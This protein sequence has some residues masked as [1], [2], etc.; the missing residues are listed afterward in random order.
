[1]V[2]VTR[3]AARRQDTPANGWSDDLRWYAAAIHR[4]KDLTPQLDDYRPMAL[5]ANDLIAKRDRTPAETQELIGLIDTMAPIIEQ[6][7]DP[8][9]LGYQAQVH[10]TWMLRPDDWPSHQGQQVLWTEC[11]HGNWFF[12]PWHRAYLLEYEAVVR[13]HIEAL[14]GPH[15][16]WGLPYW[17]S[18]DYLADP[19]A[20]LLPGPLADPFVPDDVDVPGLVA[21]PGEPRGN[22]L[23][24]PSRAGPEPLVGPPSAVDWP[25]ASAALTRRHYANADGANFVSFGGGYLEDLTQF[26]GSQELGQMDRQPHGQGHVETGGL[27]AAFRTAGLDP[28]FWM[29]HANV[30]RLWETYA[31]DLRHGYPF[32]DGRPAGRLA[33][34]A[35]DSWSEREFRFLRPDAQLGIWKAPQVLETEALGYVYDTITTPAFNRLPPPPAGQDIAPFGLAPRDFGPVAAASDVAVSDAATIVLTGGAE[36]ADG[37]GL[38]TATAE[39]NV[40]FDGIRCERPALSSYAVYLGLE[41]G[42]DGGATPDPARLVGVLALFGAFEASIEE[43][44]DV[45]FGQLFEAT[46]VV[47]DLPGFDPLSARL[48]LVPT[49]PDR[50]LESVRL[51][52]ERISLEVG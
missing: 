38:V 33:A 51:T 52:V 25:D 27:M 46:S 37:A 14:G 29:H 40:R 41:E 39:W 9:S 35:F 26:H 21:A 34:R 19:D 22:P 45:G 32:P 44:G 13:A 36:G 8:A 30:D 2:V 18:S 24:E 31:R 5:R 7:S 11:A 20:A 15:E 4:M 12:L 10:D 48:T 47:R 50:D 43:D 49:R 42:P 16:T 1:M 17:N 6:W 3:R 28:A 23:H